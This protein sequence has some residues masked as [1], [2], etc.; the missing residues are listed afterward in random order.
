VRDIT[1]L[2]NIERKYNI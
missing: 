1:Q 2:I